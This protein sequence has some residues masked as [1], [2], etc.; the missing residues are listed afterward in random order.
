MDYPELHSETGGSAKRLST[1]DGVRIQGTLA[2]G[3]KA[4]G[5]GVRCC[6]GIGADGHRSNK[7]L[8]GRGV[9]AKMKVRALREDRGLREE[10]GQVDGGKR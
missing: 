1:K 10:D 3:G 7:L 5:A 9:W 2:A 8:L 4:Y 6:W